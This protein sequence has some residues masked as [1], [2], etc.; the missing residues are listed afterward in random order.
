MERVSEDSIV[1]FRDQTWN[2][3][4]RMLRARGDHSP[5]LLAFLDGEIEQMSP[6]DSHE[7]IDLNCSRMV[8][9]YCLAH[10]IMLQGIGSWLLRDK[11]KHAGLEPDSGFIFGRKTAK[12]PDLAI[13][14]E[15]S[16]GGIDRLEIYRR[17]GIREVWRWREYTLHVH[18]LV[19]GSYREADRS[20]FLP[21][22][23]V[24]LM[25]KL[26]ELRYVND[27]VARWSGGRGR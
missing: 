2:D 24:E 12:R 4:E 8:T 25:T 16:R 18:Q 13:E 19:R 14:V 11:L 27:I 7:R 10:G 22:I 17:L 6:G 3:Y 9:D 23:H 1:V 21:E 26:L 20:R 15:W 5:P